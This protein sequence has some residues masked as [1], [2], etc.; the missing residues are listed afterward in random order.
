MRNGFVR[1]KGSPVEVFCTNPKDFCNIPSFSQGLYIRTHFHAVFPVHT[2][3]IDA[4]AC[5]SKPPERYALRTIPPTSLRSWAPPA[6]GAAGGYAVRRLAAIRRRSLSCLY[7]PY[8]SPP[9]SLHLC[10]RKCLRARFPAKVPTWIHEIALAFAYDRA[11]WVRECR[12]LVGNG[13]TSFCARRRRLSAW[14]AVGGGKGRKREE[15]GGK[16]LLKN[17]WKSY[18]NQNF[19]ATF[20]VRKN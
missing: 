16:G 9:A 10:T 15:K 2:R 20:A 19:I 8:V 4:R 17:L 7:L 11:G 1:K 14:R 5:G 3:M 13:M 6:H 12:A 18:E